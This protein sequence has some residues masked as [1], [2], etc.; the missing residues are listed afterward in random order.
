MNA[1]GTEKCSHIL[2]RW[3]IV[4]A[5]IIIVFIVVKAVGIDSA[6]MEQV[7][8]VV[9]FVLAF[10]TTFSISEITKIMK[11]IDKNDDESVKK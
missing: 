9:A 7:M 10:M 5:V 11:T 1:L 3:L 2:K 8:T 6:Q 4:S